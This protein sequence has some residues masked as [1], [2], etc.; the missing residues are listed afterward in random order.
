[1]ISRLSL[2]VAVLAMLAARVAQAGPID[3]LPANKWVRLETKPE[4]GYLLSAPVY[5]P[6]RGQLLHWGASSGTGQSRNDVRAFDPVAGDWVSDYPSEPQPVAI[7]GTSGAGAM[8]KSG[9]RPRP[10][11]VLHGGCWDS[12]RQRVVYTMKGLMVAYD[13]KT[14]TWADMQAKTILPEPLP[15]EWPKTELRDEFPGGPPVYGMST[16]YDPVNDEII[17]FPHFEAK[18]TSLRDATGQ[19]TGHFGTFRYSFADNTWRVVSDT[20]GSDEMKAA[21]K[22]LIAIMA[23]VSAALDALWRHELKPDP[24][25]HAEAIKRAAD[26][27]AAADK[28]V[29]PSPAK[30]E[31]ANVVELLTPFRGRA[32]KVVDPRRPLRDALWAMND[33]LET[34]LRVEPQ[35]RCAAPMV[36]DPKNKVIVMFGGH[37]NLARTDGGT[38]PNVMDGQNDTWLYDVTTKQWRELQTENR[39]PLG[40]FACRVPMLAYDDASGLVLLVTRTGEIWDARKPRRVA[41]WTLDVAKGQWSKRDEQDWA[42][43]LTTMS[44]QGSEGPKSHAPTA[45][46]GYDPKAKL[47]IIVQPEKA[48][49]ATYAMKLDLSKLPSEPAPAH[50]PASP[51][52]PQEIPADKPETVAWLK[53]LPAN[54][55][56]RAN[57]PREPNRRDWGSLAVDGRRGW[58]VYLGGGHSTYQI[59]DVSVYNVAANEWSFQVGDHNA[60][61]P[62]NEW[63]GSTV[64]Y[65]GGPRARHE[66]NTYNVL[67]GRVYIYVGTA[68]SQHD[69]QLYQD[70]RFV[71]FYDIDR[72]G[73]WREVRIGQE[74]RDP[75]YPQSHV[76]GMVD[77]VRG[78]LLDL[79]GVTSH[80][81]GQ[82]LVRRFF[83]I[84]DGAE[85]KLTIRETPKPYPMH[86]GLGESRSFCY[87]PDRDQVVWMSSAPADPARWAE[88]PAKDD[89]R[90][91]TFIYDVKAN[92][93]SELPAKRFPTLRPVNVVEYIDSQ[94]CLLAVINNPATKQY[95]QWVY[96]FEKQ[97]W[98]MLPL[99]IEKDAR[100]GFQSP[101][102]Q[103]VWVARHGVL[104]NMVGATWIMRPDF[105]QVKWE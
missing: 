19:I 81:Y 56:T 20:F 100:M 21:R 6:D 88:M 29:L 95:E 78:R 54:T 13:P 97:D 28:L 31:L 77:P 25:V 9:A 18:N 48:G 89:Q 16:C 41:L 105:S 52:R 91:A 53:N 33:I 35:P 85:N 51:I 46:F 79:L 104:V 87:L 37:T 72:G 99:A 98:A 4:P 43:E 23:D 22:G 15:G 92:T 80:Y 34:H 47:A 76:N 27:H 84:Y 57:P 71:R 55:W 65:R 1:M 14:K 39:P 59:N 42:G 82:D 93:W 66:R 58:V 60:Y 7:A 61:I 101:Y 90:Q 26:A 94:Q 73:V 86:R 102:G 24:A 83:R 70:E 40:R 10:A 38:G 63:E 49:Q 96:S 3:E 50:E 45:S 12:K 68:G 64:G 36:Y 103:M 75:G 44:G 11:I 62:P 30:A 69:G 74:Q 8:D 17:L 32:G 2:L 67:N 5:V